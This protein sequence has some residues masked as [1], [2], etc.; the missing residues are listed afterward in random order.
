ML[1]AYEEMETIFQHFRKDEQPFIETVIGFVREVENNY[2]PKLT[3]FLDPREC[4][5][6]ESIAKGAELQVQAYGAFS[7]AERQRMLIFPDYYSPTMEDFQVAVFQLKYPT[8]FVT[9]EHRHMLGSL[10]ALGLERSRFGDIRLEEELVQFAVAK[11]LITYLLAN[12]TEVGKTKVSIEQVTEEQWIQSTE[13]WSEQLY[14]VSS[15]RLDALVA[16]LANCSRQQASK[17]IRGE[18]VKVNWTTITE[19]AFE[20]QEADLL[21]IRGS[22]R[23]TIREIEGRTRKDRLR[24]LVGMIQ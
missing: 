4:F 2:A 10:M 24:L 14:I 15:L 3:G 5:I 8:K 13:Q 23:F 17:L 16:S 6:V 19:V 1:G 18:R 21:S 11:E 9:V 20:L 7:N 12:F 22:G